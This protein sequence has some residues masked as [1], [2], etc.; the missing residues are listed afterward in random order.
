MPVLQRGAA[1]RADR[2]LAAASACGRWNRSD[3]RRTQGEGSRASAESWPFR[4]LSFSADQ[5]TRFQLDIQV[6]ALAERRA[7][8]RHA[9]HRVSR[10]RRPARSS[11]PDA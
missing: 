11:P 5:R 3:S 7:W 2:A 1:V 6:L 8:T 4:I 9:E 10:L